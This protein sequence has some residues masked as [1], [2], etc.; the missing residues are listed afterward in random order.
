[1]ACT[2]RLVG[3]LDIGYN[4][5]FDI[6]ITHRRE[7]LQLITGEIARMPLITT[8]TIA[9]YPFTSADQFEPTSC[10]SNF[11]AFF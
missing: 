5:V 11:S 10:P 8:I 9:A 1:M 6:N 3:A 7:V 4:G 2:C